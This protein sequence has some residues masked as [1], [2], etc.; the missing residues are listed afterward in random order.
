M[1]KSPLVNTFFLLHGYLRTDKRPYKCITVKGLIDF[2][3]ILL[4]CKRRLRLSSDKVT[5]IKSSKI[6]IF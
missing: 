3:K 2:N 5:P 1:S 4:R 6:T